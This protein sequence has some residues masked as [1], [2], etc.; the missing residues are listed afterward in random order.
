[1]NK[2]EFNQFL[3]DNYPQHLSEMKEL[4]EVFGKPKS[5]KFE[6]QGTKLW[7]PEQSSTSLIIKREKGQSTTYSTRLNPQSSYLKSQLGR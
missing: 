4:I 7:P 3:S 5:Y 6:Y 2:E 1:M